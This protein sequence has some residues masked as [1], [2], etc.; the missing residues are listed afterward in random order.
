MIVGKRTW[1]RDAIARARPVRLGPVEVPLVGAA[2]LILLQLSGGGQD[3]ADMRLILTA[4]DR[5]AIAAEVEAGLPGL[6]P[7]GAACGARS[8]RRTAESA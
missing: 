2:D 8:S 3:A 5:D 6:P 1:Q 7:D 4:V